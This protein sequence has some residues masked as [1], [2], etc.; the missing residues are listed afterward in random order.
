MTNFGVR[1]LFLCGLC[2]G[3]FLLFLFNKL[4]LYG[5]LQLWGFHRSAIVQEFLESLWFRGF[6]RNLMILGET[7][8][9]LRFYTFDCFGCCWITDGH[10]LDFVLFRD[11]IALR[12][13]LGFSSLGGLGV[14]YR[15]D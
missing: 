11:Y 15:V 13:C 14:S 5:F 2:F 9:L 8:I 3:L 4:P 12:W 6:L 10:F 1:L 7:A